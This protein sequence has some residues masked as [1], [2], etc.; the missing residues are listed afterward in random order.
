MT[1]LFTL[2]PL[3]LALAAIAIAAF[4]WA[5]ND[6]QFEDLDAAANSALEE[7]EAT[8]SRAPS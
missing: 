4:F 6:G 1:I 3:S 5:V 2:I 7:E 8:A